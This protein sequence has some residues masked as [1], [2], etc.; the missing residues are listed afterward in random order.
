M[1][2]KKF[3]KTNKGI[4]SETVYQFCEEV[5]MKHKKSWFP[6]GIGKMQCWGCWRYGKKVDTD[7]KI[8]NIC[9][10]NHPE[11]RGC[12]QINKLYDK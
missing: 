8:S 4:P 11:N 5:R 10:F 9:A 3:S 12:W 1:R 6:F 2:M 7:G